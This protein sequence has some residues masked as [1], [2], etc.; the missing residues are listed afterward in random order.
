MPL[1][2][3][4][5][6]NWIDGT[7]LSFAELKQ[8]LLMLDAYLSRFRQVPT[9]GRDT[10]RRFSSNISELKKLAARD[11]EDILQVSSVS[12]E[13]V[14]KLIPPSLSVRFRYLMVSFPS[15]TIKQSNVYSSPV[16][17]GMGLP[18]FACTPTSP[19]TFLM[20]SQFS[21]EL[22]FEHLCALRVQ[23]LIHENFAA[24]LKAEN[25][26]NRRRQQ[27][28]ETLDLLPLHHPMET[29]PAGNS[30]TSRG[31]NI[32]HSV[33]MLKIYANS[34]LQIRIRRNRFVY[35]YYAKILMLIVLMS[36][37]RA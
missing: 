4:L 34:V 28:E 15:P 22:N 13:Y 29:N 17:I 31:I 1:I 16:H 19:S 24:K 33:I 25:V 36:V 12:H 26:A 9:F 20:T 8:T 10:I 35:L 32:T 18:N 3:Q 14:V 11:F 6:M 23:P 27:A 37:G 5:L 7:Q 2:R 30:S 21:L